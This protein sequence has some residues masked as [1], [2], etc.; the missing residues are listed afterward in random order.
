[1]STHR[2]IIHIPRRQVIRG[3]LATVA[4][5]ATTKLT[6]C[7]SDGETGTADGG[8]SDKPLVIGF[9]YVGAKDDYG[10]NQAHALGAQEISK[11][12]GVKLVE[13]A[14]VPETKEVQEVMRNMIEQDGATVIF[15]T[16]FGYFKPHTIEMAKQYPDVQFFHC[17]TLWQDG[18]PTNIGNYYAATDEGQYIAGRIAAQSTKSGKLGFVAAKPV[19]PVLR[20]IN[21]FIMGARSVKPDIT[22]QVIFTGDWNVPVKEAEATNSL[23]DQGIDV[24]GVHVDSPKVVIET[25]EKRGILSAGYHADQSTLAPKGYLTGTTYR[26]GQVYKEY[27]DQIKAGKKVADGGIPR[28]SQGSL[29]ENYIQMAPFGPAVSDAVKKDADATIA[30]FVDG[31]LI[32]YTGEIKDNTGKVRVP[33]GT[34]YKLTDPELDKVDWLANGVIG[35]VS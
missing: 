22:M 31:S 6:A 35:S 27:V 12:P 20:N 4:F 26:W 33:K 3:I 32:V 7:S 17:S 30:K 18:M 5:A 19:N 11:L 9:I 10:W 2:S 23:A 15:P 21:G 8:A 24:I 25:A 29:K 1:M 13:Q 14:S 34:A 16:S 28:I